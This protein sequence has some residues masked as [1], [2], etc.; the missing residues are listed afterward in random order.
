MK[1]QT[2]ILLASILAITLIID[3]VT[4]YIVTASLR[5]GEAIEIIPS[6][7]QIRYV[8]NTGAAWSIFEGKMTFFYIVT[9]VALV[10]LILFLRNMKNA[11]LIAYTGI[12][13]AIS[14]TIGNFIDRLTLQYVRDFLDF[15]IFGYDFPVF[16]VADMC[17]VI[18]IGLIVLD[19]LRTSFGGKLNVR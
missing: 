9:V 4:K 18:G 2:K 14:G 19:E 7:F 5:L 15:T 6:F 17:L 3:Q 12:I 10:L 16:N 1:K 11:S 8:Q 13:L